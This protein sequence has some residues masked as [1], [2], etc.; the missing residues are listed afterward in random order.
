MTSQQ[1]WWIGRAMRDEDVIELDDCDHR[2]M[3][4][5]FPPPRCANCG[6]RAGR[7]GMRPVE[8]RRLPWRLWLAELVMRAAARYVGRHPTD[9]NWYQE[10]KDNG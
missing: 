2:G 5:W 1:P 4:V 3:L 10:E 7:R 6:H 9:R 8:T